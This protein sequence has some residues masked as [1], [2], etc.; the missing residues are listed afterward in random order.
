MRVDIY[1]TVWG[2]AYVEKFLTYS[3]A[4]QLAPG[5]IPA[6]A[7]ADVSF[8]YHIYTDRDSEPHFHPGIEALARHAEIRF[9]F[10]EDIP[11]KGATLA[12]AMANSPPASVKHNVQRLTSLRFVAE[13]AREKSDAVLLLDS[14]FIFSDGSWPAL[15]AARRAGA[16]AVCA[17]FLRLDEGIAAPLLKD[18]I[19][20]GMGP[21]EIVA[22]GLA[23]LHPIARSMFVDADPFASYPSQLNWWVG[24]PD[25][26]A[27][28]VTH[29]FFP[30]PLLVVP[31][32]GV[33]Y[34]S[35]MDYEF[36]LRAASDDSA[37]RLIRT[38]DEL[39]VCKMTPS[40]YLAD[41]PMGSG[42]NLADI[43]RFTVSN[44]NIRH[45]LFMDQPIR[46]VAGGSDEV[47]REAE[48]QSAHYVE[49]IYKAA[50]LILG[51]ANTD[52][53][54]L[55]F[56]KSFLGPIEDF[57]SPQTAARLK[58]WMSGRFVRGEPQMRHI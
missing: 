22:V 13:A 2:A 43:A 36:A 49:A 55:V 17:M 53:R 34:A 8:V 9:R 23:A 26:Q 39:L 51:H 45:R 5:N 28:L 11:Y 20:Q 18:R 31:R 1:V 4:S 7:G 30:H 40:S 42:A 57:A 32:D 46:F 24:P 54:S 29:C 38:S 6:L 47:W 52:A 56:L 41:R 10:Y 25:A 21:R 50:E 12:D 19:A 37:I 15:I 14:D 3:L 48:I 44:T 35:T 16:E 33:R 58:G 27:G